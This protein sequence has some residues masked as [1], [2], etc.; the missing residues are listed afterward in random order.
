MIGNDGGAHGTTNADIASQTQDPTWF[1]MDTGLNTIE[2]YSGNIVAISSMPP[3]HRQ[4]VVRRT[5]APV[6][7]PLPAHRPGQCY[8]NS[9]WA[10]TG[11][12][13]VLTPWVLGQVSAFFKVTTEA[14]LAVALVTAPISLRHGRAS[15]AG[16]SATRGLSWCH[17]TF[18]TAVFRAVMTARQPAFPAGAAI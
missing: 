10:V 18:S 5:T 13:R 12:T 9:E 7:S 1:N 11:S 2:F 8:G 6:P 15:R 17:T 14:P 4:A 3:R 16:G